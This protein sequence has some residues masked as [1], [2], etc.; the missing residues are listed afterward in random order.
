M[1]KL[2]KYPHWDI[3]KYT[4]THTLTYLLYTDEDVSIQTNSI[5]NEWTSEWMNEW[6]NVRERNE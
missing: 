4:Y 1:Q 5:W 2:F 6:M 3:Q